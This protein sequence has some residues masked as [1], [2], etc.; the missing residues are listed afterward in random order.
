[1]S[2]EPFIGTKISLIS[3][4]GIRYEGLLHSLNTDEATIILNDVRCMGTE[5]R[6]K[7]G[8]VPPSSKVHD[9]IVFRG[10][11][12][13]D[14]TVDDSGSSYDPILN[15]PAICKTYNKSQVD[16]A[17]GLPFSSQATSNVAQPTVQ[18]APLHTTQGAMPPASTFMS[19]TPAIPRPENIFPA[20][21]HFPT[22]HENLD[23]LTP[24]ETGQKTRLSESA[25]DKITGSVDRVLETF[26]FE[27]TEKASTLNEPLQSG[28]F[29]GGVSMGFPSGKNGNFGTLLSVNSSSSTVPS[30]NKPLFTGTNT[31]SVIEDEQPV[32]YDKKS[33]YDNLSNEKQ[34]SR[35]AIKEENMKQREIDIA[36]FGKSS[37]R[38]WKNKN[39]SH[40]N[41]K[42][43]GNNNHKSNP[44]QAG[45]EKKQ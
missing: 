17:G 22:K 9:F 8:E 31:A 26:Q 37:V 25:L 44:V 16:A 13:S 38:Y 43:S 3:K 20:K 41:R 24:F 39:A 23:H 36:T 5:G 32:Y 28:G 4:V 34:L 45:W 10:E 42:F 29:S 1:M 18:S 40:R 35:D 27:D 21:S 30:I 11:D 15:D 7:F 33:F 14:I 6:G 12:V 2:I 19:Q